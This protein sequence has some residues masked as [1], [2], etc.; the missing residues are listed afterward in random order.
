M[1]LHL[2]NLPSAPGRY[3]ETKLASQVKAPDIKKMRTEDS[4]GHS[5]KGRTS[6]SARQGSH[7][8]YESRTVRN[9]YRLRNAVRNYRKS[10]GTTQ[11]HYKN[12]VL[13][14][15]LRN[16]RARRFSLARASPYQSVVRCTCASRAIGAT[17]ILFRTY[18]GAPP[19]RIFGLVTPQPALFDQLIKSKR[20]ARRR[21]N[22]LRSGF[23]QDD[24]R[25]AEIPDGTRGTVQPKA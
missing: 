25:G 4:C 7:V 11:R 5:E 2:P 21:K 18:T 20:G 22:P 13:A 16:Q 19:E 15:R 17:G 8:A 14:Y 6:A 12:R 10:T 3:G 9:S 23:F 1:R 24:M